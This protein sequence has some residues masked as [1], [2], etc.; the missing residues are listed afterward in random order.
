MA[1]IRRVDAAGLHDGRVEA[2][3]KQLQQRLHVG[4]P[5]PAAG[6]V[7]EAAV[8][9]CDDGQHEGGVDTL[10][11]L[12]RYKGINV[13]TELVTCRSSEADALADPGWHARLGVAE[14]ST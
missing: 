2:P 7:T 13:T 6:R 8:D 9:L 3:G 12:R 11:N 1:G 14:Y 10:D 5:R 4:L